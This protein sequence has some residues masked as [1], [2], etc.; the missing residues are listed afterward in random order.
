MT[1]WIISGED[2]IAAAKVLKAASPPFGAM[3]KE[4]AELEG[5]RTGTEAVTRRNR[6]C[7]DKNGAGWAGGTGGV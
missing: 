2:P 1:S 3:V 7:A 6:R 4:Q 5:C